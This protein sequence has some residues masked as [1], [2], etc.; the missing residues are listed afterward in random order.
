MK[1]G[2]G[3]QEFSLLRWISQRGEV[4]VGDA[5]AAFGAPRGLARSTVLTMMERLRAKRRL[6]R[7]RGEGVYLYGATEAPESVLRGLVHDFVE[8]TLDGSVS[9]FVAYLTET[10]KLTEEE[11]AELD[12]LVAKLQSRRGRSRS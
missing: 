8:T 11:L 7:R 2:L 1:K 3:R 9:P 12:E 5:A 6:R 10:G 4:S